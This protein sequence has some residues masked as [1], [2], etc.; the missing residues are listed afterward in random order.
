MNTV[1]HQRYLDF[2]DEMVS[3]VSLSGVRE[4]SSFRIRARCASFCLC[5]AASCANPYTAMVCISVSIIWMVQQATVGNM[6][7]VVR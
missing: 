3:F 4:L 5:I 7:E 1:G 6:G 2:A